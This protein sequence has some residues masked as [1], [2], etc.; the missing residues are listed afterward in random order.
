MNVLDSLPAMSLSSYW[1][2]ISDDFER[3]VPLDLGLTKGSQQSQEVA[4]KIWKFYFGDATTLSFS[5]KDQYVN[6][7]TDE[8]FVCGIHE[9]VKVQSALYDNIYNYQFSFNRGHRQ[10]SDKSVVVTIMMSCRHRVQQGHRITWNLT[11]TDIVACTDTDIIEPSHGD[12]LNYLFYSGETFTPG[13]ASYDVH[14]WLVNLWSSFAKNGTAS[15]YPFGLYA[16]STNYSN[17]LGIGKVELEEVNPHLRGGRVENNLGKT[18]PVHPT[19]IRTSISPSSAVELNTTSALANYATEAVKL[20]V[21]SPGDGSVVWTPAS[22]SNLYYLQINDTL[23]LE[24]NLEEERMAFWDDIYT[25][26]TLHLT[27]VFLK[28]S[29]VYGKLIVVSDYNSVFLTLSEVGCELSVSTKE[30]TRLLYVTSN[31]VRGES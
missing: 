27:T 21:P 14:K 28:R 31:A 23:S 11:T 12:E 1:E 10:G 22:S 4:D 19:E 2:P 5:S 3:V 17:E 13:E 6:L 20:S 24:K 8:M 7:I 15:Y 26:A 18:T 9:T 29:D 16:L 30:A 25:T